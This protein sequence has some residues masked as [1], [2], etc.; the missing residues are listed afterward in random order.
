MLGFAV[1]AVCLVGLFATVRRRHHAAC[2]Y[3][4]R[5]HHAHDRHFYEGFPGGRR[6]KR[7]L[8]RALFVKLDT[9]PGQ[10][11][12]IVSAVDRLR[13]HVEEAR[14]GL[15][16]TRRELAALLAEDVLDRA[17]LTALLGQKRE[18]AGSLTEAFEETLSQIHE[19]LDPE[20]REQLAAWL[21][22]GAF[23]R[24]FT[25]RRTY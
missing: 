9:S 20:Q 5:L 12:A 24:S 21:A 1:G 6:S 14:E 13:A 3:C 17:A 7:A 15:V 8:L 4:G 18:L 16:D 19:A 25:R 10:E 23:P 11:K 22:A 2:G